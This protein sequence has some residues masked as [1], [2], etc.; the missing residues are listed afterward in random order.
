[1]E[2]KEIT[3]FRLNK[4]LKRTLKQTAKNEYRSMSALVEMILTQHFN[5]QSK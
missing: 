4:D 5:K 3:S 2:T 1:M